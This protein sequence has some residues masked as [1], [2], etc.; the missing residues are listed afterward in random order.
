MKT[1][2]VNRKI[3][4]INRRGNPAPRSTSARKL[5]AWV[6]TRG[7]DV[8]NGPG[9]V[10]VEMRNGWQDTFD[11]FDDAYA[12]VLKAET[13]FIDKGTPY[14]WD[15]PRGNPKPRTVALLARKRNPTGGA[16]LGIEVNAGNDRNGNRR[17][18]WVVV[19]VS[20]G[21]TGV[22]R[23]GFV[24]AGY[25]GDS[26]LRSTYGRIPTIGVFDISPAS[27]KSLKSGRGL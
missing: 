3:D 25:A 24:D 8:K 1:D 10:T 2:T 16:L 18:G 6:R 17:S 19:R 20:E 22:E 12:F 15:A 26:E 9:W 4:A 21:P 5:R 13:R 23:V 14:P 27:Y 7:G 11:N